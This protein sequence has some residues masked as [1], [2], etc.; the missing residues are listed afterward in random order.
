MTTASHP[1]LNLEATYTFNATNS[2]WEF[3]GGLI[4]AATITNLTDSPNHTLL[5]TVAR[6]IP[7]PEI[8]LAWI[9]V[10]DNV[11]HL[12]P[13][14]PNKLLTNTLPPGSSI[15]IAAWRDPEHERGD[16]RA[17]LNVGLGDP[18]PA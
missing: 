15:L 6:G 5:V 17:N 11:T 8:H 18:D 1:A 14:V 13:I 4:S 9:D 10:T 7:T 3:N 2:G 16:I 12:R